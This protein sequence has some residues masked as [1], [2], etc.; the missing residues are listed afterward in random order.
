MSGAGPAD[1]WAGFLRNPSELG[2]FRERL[3][4]AMTNCL[5]AGRSRP[6]DRHEL[7][8]MIARRVTFDGEPAPDD[9]LP[10]YRLSKSYLGDLLS[11][12]KTNPSTGVVR[13]LGAFFGVGAAFFVDSGDYARKI[14]AQ[15]EFVT[16]V[17]DREVYLLAQRAGEL[18]EQSLELW[19]QQLDLLLRIQ[20]GPVSQQRA[21]DAA[22]D[23]GREP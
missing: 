21:A 9:V 3:A 15:V 8:E 16:S 4:W 18:T 6:F 7:T 2:T 19:R 13:T 22:P 12:E 14:A 17:R 1:A 11:G 5:P 23:P 20:G 10:L